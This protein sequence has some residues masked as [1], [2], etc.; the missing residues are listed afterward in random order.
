M[1]IIFSLSV[2]HPLAL[3]THVL[4]QLQANVTKP[5]GTI[6]TERVVEAEI[7]GLPE[8]ARF[9]RRIASEVNTSTA[10]VVIATVR[11]LIAG[12]FVVIDTQRLDGR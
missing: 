7:A 11:V 5:T 1:V 6:A 2:D 10:L 3:V 4:Q 8:S 12:E 9:W